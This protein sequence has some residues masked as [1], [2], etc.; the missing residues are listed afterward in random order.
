MSS[1][2]PGD[3]VVIDGAVQGTFIGTAE[4][5]KYVIDL[6]YG[7]TLADPERVIRLA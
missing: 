3:K 5:G 7:S 1:I 6:G 2:K 4:S